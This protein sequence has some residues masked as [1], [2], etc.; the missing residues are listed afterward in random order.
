VKRIPNLVLIVIVVLSVTI[1]SES[2]A[3]GNAE[4]QSA[5]QDMGNLDYSVYINANKL[6]MFCSN[7]GSFAF[8]KSELFGYSSGLFYPYTSVADILDASNTSTAAFA[9]GLWLA[10][11]VQGDIRVAIGEYSS[12]F[13]PGPM[14][15]GTF[16]PGAGTDPQYRVYKL[17]SD[18]MGSNPNT[19]YNEWPIG[20]GAPV[21]IHGN[22]LLLGDQTFWTVFNDAD[23]AGQN[24]STGTTLP[25]G[26]ELQSTLWAFDTPGL[27]QV[28]FGRY[29]L[30]N[31]GANQ[32][33]DFYISI[34]ADVDIGGVGDER[35]GCDTLSDIIF[36]Y[37][38]GVDAVFGDDPP[39][40]GIRI[41]SGPVVSSP[42][43]TA[44]FDG[45]PLPDYRNMR[46]TSFLRYINGL[47]PDSAEWTY[48]YIRG[49]DHQG[50]PP[51][52]GTNFQ[53]PGDPVAGTGD[54]DPFGGNKKMLGSFGPLQF[55]PGDSQYVYFK[56]GVGQGANHLAS[57][58]DMKALLNAPDSVL[59]AVPPDQPSSL[60]QEFSL[61]QNYPNPFN[62]STTISYTVPERSKVT[63]AVYNVI[64]Q[65]V[66]TLVN[67]IKPVGS[68][69]VTWDGADAAGAEVASGIYF[70]RL[71]AGEIVRTRKMLLLK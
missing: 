14:I 4:M 56:I 25:L 17:Y 21:D 49:I 3:A 28:V 64:G 59:T 46:M 31:K 66:T 37:N 69:S 36:A 12:D 55:N 2:S 5:N 54:L 20:Q 53:V 26:I 22:P 29:K 40:T 9:A 32:I 44:D 34:W 47:D 27:D 24:A 6:L 70:Y 33:S 67:E 19:D 62:P 65:K 50:N 61:G 71:T 10:G 16:D 52:N 18:S 63:L 42:G 39:A 1:P 15:S 43:D 57:V 7:A 23:S 68:Y 38:E 30:Y 45:N 35:F 41:I 58:T 60:P 8:D 11:R 48:D 13:G 51:S